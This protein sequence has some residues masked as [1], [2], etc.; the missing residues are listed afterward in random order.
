MQDQNPTQTTPKLLKFREVAELTKQSV[1]NV[2][3]LARKGEFPK[4]RKLTANSTVWLESEVIDWINRRLG[5]DTTAT[6]ATAKA[7]QP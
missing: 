6:D 1:T 2:Y 4:P 7:V 3:T 5:I